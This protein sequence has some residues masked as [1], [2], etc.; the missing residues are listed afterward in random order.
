MVFISYSHDSKPFAARVLKLAKKLHRDGVPTEIDQYYE[1]PEQGWPLWMQHS[2]NQA[3]HVLVICSPL[4]HEKL[5]H[6]PK[7]K[8][9]G[10]GVKW[11]SLLTYN[12][13]YHAEGQNKKFIPVIMNR[14]HER[15]VPDA[16]SGQTIYF[17]PSDYRKLKNRLLG[18]SESLRPETDADSGEDGG[19]ATKVATRKKQTAKE[20]KTKPATK[21]G[22]IDIVLNKSFQ[23]FN[24]T[25]R[26]SFL[27]AVEAL[28]EGKHPIRVKSVREGSVII[29]LE[30][31]LEARDKLFELIKAG[32]LQDYAVILIA[33]STSKDSPELHRY[34]RRRSIRQKMLIRRAMRKR[35]EQKESERAYGGR[36]VARYGSAKSRLR[37]LKNR[38]EARKGVSI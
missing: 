14:D 37:W 10:K 25:E 24:G 7:A 21:M 15:F 8:G 34:L 20:K 16:L 33:L 4:Y 19:T 17:Y 38:R 26:T 13:I 27:K 22:Y 3:D 31:P 2:L 28:L 35:E 30:L 32:A 5:M 23:G 6:G 18:T 9:V 11:E 29:K 1:S 12:Q 36:F